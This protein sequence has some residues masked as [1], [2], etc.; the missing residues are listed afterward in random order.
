MLRSMG[1]VKHKGDWL[2]LR[3][4]QES[5]VSSRPLAVCDVQQKPIFVRGD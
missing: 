5:P 2:L 3:I 4:L 1:W